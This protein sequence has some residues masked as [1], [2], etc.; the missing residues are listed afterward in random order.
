MPDPITHITSPALVATLAGASS[1]LFDLDLAIVITAFGGAYYAV[2][3][4]DSK[5]VMQS[6]ALILISMVVACIA[7]HAINWLADYFFNIKNLPQRPL[8]F[9]LGFAVIDKQVREQI[10]F[11]IQSKV[12][13]NEVSK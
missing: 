8:A 7:V 11:F 10:Y 9:I 2:Y 12:K 4:D 1:F 13:V 3:R 6:I 5:R